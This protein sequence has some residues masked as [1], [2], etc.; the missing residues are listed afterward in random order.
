MFIHVRNKFELWRL[1]LI[2]RFLDCK[3]VRFDHAADMHRDCLFNS[4]RSGGLLPM[5]ESFR[6]FV[7][8][9]ANRS[10]SW[11]LQRT[12]KAPR[13]ATD[14]RNS[15]ALPDRTWCCRFSVKPFARLACS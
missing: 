13:W 5:P 8:T 6:Y 1:R 3:R 4:G 11:R 14:Y 12:L 10:Q 2:H 15:T 7:W 9:G